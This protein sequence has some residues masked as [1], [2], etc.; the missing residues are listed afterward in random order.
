MNSRPTGRRQAKK[1]Q[2]SLELALPFRDH[3][4]HTKNNNSYQ[5]LLFKCNLDYIFKIKN[6]KCYENKINV[7]HAYESDH[8]PIVTII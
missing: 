8:L 7:I 6:N 2:L 1:T 5:H 4:L 3:I